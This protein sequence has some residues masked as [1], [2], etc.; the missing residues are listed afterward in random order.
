[1]QKHQARVNKI[2]VRCHPEPCGVDEPGPARFSSLDLAS[3]KPKKSLI[4]R[5]VD[6][7]IFGVGAKNA[8]RN[9]SVF[10]FSSAWLKAF[11]V[12]LFDSLCSINICSLPDFT[13]RTA[14]EAK[15]H[16]RRVLPTGGQ[17]SSPRLTA[18]FG[19]IFLTK[20]LFSRSSAHLAMFGCVIA[21]CYPH[22]KDFLFLSLKAK[23]AFWHREKKTFSRR[24]GWCWCGF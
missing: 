18:Q 24:R 19:Q 11:C 17:F 3:Y 16:N 15:V 7:T 8:S 5:I 10:T 23:K 6:D 21:A 1:M 20:N 14:F 13:P 12:L 9:F 2:I 22:F 4:N